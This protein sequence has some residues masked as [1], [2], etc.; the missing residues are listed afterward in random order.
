MLFFFKFTIF[1]DESTLTCWFNNT[2]VKSITSS[3]NQNLETVNHWLNVNKLKVN[4]HNIY[5]IVFSCRKKILLRPIRL[6]IE[7][8]AQAE[9]KLGITSNMNLL[10]RLT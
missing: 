3:I 4:T 8:I 1:A 6:G 5:H 10:L 9:K 7:I 2:T